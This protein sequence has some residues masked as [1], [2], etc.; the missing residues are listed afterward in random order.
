MHSV[1]GSILGERM[2]YLLR[3]YDLPELQTKRRSLG[4]SHVLGP[5]LHPPHLAI[6]VARRL[7]LKVC[8]RLRRM[9]YY[10]TVFGFSARLDDGRRVYAES[11][12]RPAQ[13]STTFLDMLLVFWERVIPKDKGVQ[14][15]KLSVV[16]YGLVQ[17]DMIQ[18]DLFDMF[19][20]KPTALVTDFMAAKNTELVNN[21]NM[22]RMIG[23][24]HALDRIN[25]RFGCDSALIGMLP[26]QGRSF[27]GTKIAFTRIPDAEEFLE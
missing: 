16:L 26:S 2:W 8:S 14:I 9:E 10:A 20:T 18:P 25:H 4:H 23:L 6:N 13:D 7:T 15:K 5:A 1:W 12:C 27:S 3:G 11:R 21:R 19:E 17:Q 24:S 22:T